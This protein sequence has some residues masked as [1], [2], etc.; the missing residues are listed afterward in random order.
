[1]KQT[2]LQIVFC[3]YN[4]SHL[5]QWARDQNLQN[6]TEALAPLIQASQLLQA[7]K[8]EDDVQSICDM[9]NLLKSNQIVKILNNYTPADEY[10]T[11]VPISFIKK[12]EDNLKD[13]KDNNDQVRIAIS[14]WILILSLF[15]WTL[16][17]F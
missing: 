16:I 13:R 2:N 3:R 5:E 1:M 12:V 4:L 7:R 8:T 10:E 6:A 17:T 15:F 11:R 14:L 9:C